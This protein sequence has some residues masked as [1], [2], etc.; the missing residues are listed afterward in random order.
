M[1]GVV[2][3][4]W[5]ATVFRHR[6]F[7]EAVA[8][9]APLALRYGATKYAVHRNLDD[10][11][12]ITQM[13]WFESKDDWYRFWESPEM[14]EFRARNMGRY[15]VPVVY[16]WAEELAAGELGPH[17]PTA[18]GNGRAPEPTPELEPQLA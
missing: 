8:A 10:R 17:V 1:A 18:D 2:Y 12:K 14:I 7:G 16:T 4:P 3:I 9:V 13:V 6:G 11:Y 5:Y 15:Q